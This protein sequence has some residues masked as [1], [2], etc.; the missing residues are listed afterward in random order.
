[1]GAQRRLLEKLLLAE[2]WSSQDF[3]TTLKPDI[4]IPILQ[5]KK[6]KHEV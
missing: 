5:M 2:C 4:I 6:L 1:M 3:I